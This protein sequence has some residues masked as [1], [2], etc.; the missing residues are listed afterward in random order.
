MKIDK[1]GQFSCF[2]GSSSEQYHLDL[3][4]LSD[5]KMSNNYHLLPQRT[6]L[7]SINYHKIPLRVLLGGVKNIH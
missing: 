7:I 5:L 3:D 6:F 4:H 2:D 1:K